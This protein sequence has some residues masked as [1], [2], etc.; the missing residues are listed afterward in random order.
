MCH[1]CH[2]Q[3][4]LK[5]NFKRESLIQNIALGES[6][7]MVQFLCP[8]FYVIIQILSYMNQHIRLGANFK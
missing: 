1:F 2:C 7:L 8:N 3:F 5:E 4:Y 6:C